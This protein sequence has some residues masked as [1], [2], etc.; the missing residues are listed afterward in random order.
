IYVSARLIF[1]IKGFKIFY[2]GFISLIYFILYLC[3]LEIVPLICI[4][5][6]ALDIVG[7]Q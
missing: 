6:I 5:G 3:T 2:N 7:R 1:I 4:G